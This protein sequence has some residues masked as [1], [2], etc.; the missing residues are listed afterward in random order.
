MLL[1][2]VAPLPLRYSSVDNNIPHSLQA[3][4]DSWLDGHTLIL[5]TLHPISGCPIT[6]TDHHPPTAIGGVKSVDN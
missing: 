6:P 1:G 2:T 5:M 4:M 3:S